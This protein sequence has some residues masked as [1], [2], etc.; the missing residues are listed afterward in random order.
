MKQFIPKIY[1]ITFDLWFYGTKNIYVF[2]VSN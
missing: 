2:H 1:G